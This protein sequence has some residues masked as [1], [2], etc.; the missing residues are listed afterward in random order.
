M[1]ALWLD[2]TP[3][4]LRRGGVVSAAAELLWF[5]SDWLQSRHG[6]EGRRFAA[7]ALWEYY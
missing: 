7:L 1:V 5:Q 6:S 2:V 4:K 3:V